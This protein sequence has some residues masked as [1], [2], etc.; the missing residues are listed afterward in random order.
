MGFHTF[1]AAQADRLEDPGRYR[2]CSRDELIVALDISEADHVLDLGSG[3]G[4]YTDDVAAVAGSVSAIDIQAA[5][6]AAYADKGIP[7]NVECIEAG[8]DD[9]PLADDSATS[10]L[11]TMTFHELPL[12]G[13]MDE[14]TRVLSPGARFVV[15]D[16]SKNGEGVAGAP[17]EERYDAASAAD[18]LSA[19]GFTIEHASER[20]ETYLIVGVLE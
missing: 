3:T 2:Y 5:M 13:T 16:W 10:A 19:S 9:I 18:T 6:H 20:P 8:T 7:E 17:L 14:V 1:D 15:V 11:S 12:V 4:F